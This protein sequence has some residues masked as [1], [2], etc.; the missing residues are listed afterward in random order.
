MGFQTAF[1]ETRPS[2]ESES[3]ATFPRE[4]L[5]LKNNVS[6]DCLPAAEVVATG[7]FDSSSEVAYRSGY[8]HFLMFHDLS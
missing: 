2:A 6:G 3:D 8:D 5:R 1:R 7:L 4:C